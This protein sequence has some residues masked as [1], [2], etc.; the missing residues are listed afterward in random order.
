MDPLK[1]TAY[2]ESRFGIYYTM[3]YYEES[4]G[5]MLAIVEASILPYKD[6]TTQPLL[7]LHG[8]CTVPIRMP[9]FVSESRARAR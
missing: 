9:V 1:T 6:P 2:V 8:G 4:C 5:I 7:A 3:A